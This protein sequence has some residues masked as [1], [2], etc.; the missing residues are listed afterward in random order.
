MELFLVAIRSL[1]ANKLRT[2]LTLLGII[3]GVAAVIT[4]VT[5][6]NGLESTVAST[7]SS[8]GSTV[9]TVS[10][11]PQV[12]TSREQLIETNKRRDV[13]REDGE[14][15]RRLCRIC[16]RVG[17]SAQGRETIKHGDLRS[18]NVPVRGVT[19]SMFEIEALGI[20]TGRVW[21]EAEGEAG[22]DVAVVGSDIVK[23]VFDDAPPEQVVGKTLRVGGL[24]LRIVGVAAPLGSVFGFSRDNFVYLPFE[25]GQ[26]L[27]GSRESLVVNIQVQNSSDF[28]SAKDSVRTILRNRR[29]KTFSDEDDGFA[30]ESQD[31]FLGLFNTAT[32]N[33]FIVTIG[34]AAL[35]LVVGGIVV[36]NIMLVSVT[37]RTKE[38]G[39]RKALGARRK[40]I[41]QQFLIESVTVTAI[42]GT[43]GVLVGFVMAYLIS[44]AIGFPTLASVQSAV[45]GVG[46]SSIVGIISG[47]YP[48]WRAAKLDPIEALR[49]E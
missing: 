28:E 14:A 5:I 41:L 42:G 24:E 15:I 36:M 45:L 20:Q 4:V 43:L 49:S 40:D 13:T 27:F 39:I 21:T 6:I 7:F 48:A 18:E 11:R 22:R 34:V 8:Q 35:S 19:L 33:I 32:D 16:W 37:E 2:F 25:T 44:L 9:F 47:L 38:I 17:Y 26:K 46:V 31:V 12:I 30:L 10:K 29:G 3:V 23:N 1:R